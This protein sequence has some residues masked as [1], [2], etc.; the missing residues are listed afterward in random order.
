MAYAV[1]I[2]RKRRIRVK[3]LKNSPLIRIEFAMSVVKFVCTMKINAPTCK[4]KNIRYQTWKL[5]SV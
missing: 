5:E 4:L 2:E 3:I 1:W